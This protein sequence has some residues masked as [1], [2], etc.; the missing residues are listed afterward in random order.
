MAVYRSPPP[1]SFLLFIIPSVLVMVFISLLGA[2]G[3]DGGVF[4]LFKDLK[5]G[6]WIVLLGVIRALWRFV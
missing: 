6:V 4:F 5:F 1:P 2:I 3:G